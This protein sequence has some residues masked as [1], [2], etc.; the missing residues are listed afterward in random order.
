MM[1]SY[2]SLGSS[3]WFALCFVEVPA[4][5]PSVQLPQQKDMD[6]PVV[7]NNALPFSSSIMAP[8]SR[9]APA[10]HDTDE[11]GLK[12]FEQVNVWI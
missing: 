2:R 9:P 3:L 11:D 5:P 6:I 8:I 7:I 10:P 1:L 4:P 12:H